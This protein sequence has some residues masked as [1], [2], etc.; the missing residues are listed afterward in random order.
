MN[1]RLDP[2]A[3]LLQHRVLHTSTL[4]AVVAIPVCNE[5]DRIGACL[6]AFGRQAGLSQGSF[7]I[8][9]LLNNCTD[10]TSEVVASTISRLLC[11]VRVLERHYA[12]ASAGWARRHAMDAASEWLADTL[13]DDGLILT[14]DADTRVA[15]DWI[16][17]NLAYI[18]AGADAV[19]GRYA[20]DTSEAAR[21]P[22]SLR[23]RGSCEAEYEALLVEIGARLDPEPG[24]P[25]PCHWTQSGATLSVR[26]SIYEQ[27]G[28]MPDLSLG[29]DQA[30]AEL[31]KTYD[32]RLR[33]APDIEVITSGRLD[34]R[35]IGGAADTMKRR[36]QIPD[37][38]CDDRLERLDRFLLRMLWR[39]HLRRSHAKG[40]LSCGRF[41]AIVLAISACKLRV[42]SRL[43][44]L[45]RSRAAIEAASLRLSYRPLSPS[46]LPREI[47]RA[48][49]VL[50]LLRARN[51]I[52]CEEL[53]RR[54]TAAD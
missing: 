49:F 10:R 4:K 44:T 2:S 26:R 25:W 19:A 36:A 41:W 18:A 20:L 15:T 24:D 43:D 8:L 14:T 30:F 16:A 45:G 42:L 7:G 32:L 31:L 39:R 21:L 47:G 50:R 37:S 54:S 9:L 33:H 38:P 12:S 28:G 27:V 40:E 48:K 23:A 13:C 17:K 52:R 53:S 5:E 11:P 1:E 34:G 35:A 22:K 46:A 29:E 6:E 3:L 51:S